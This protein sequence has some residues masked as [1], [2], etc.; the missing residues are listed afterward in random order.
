M[1]SVE[2][3]ERRQPDWSQ[4]GIAFVPM[5]DQHHQSRQSGDTSLPDFL[6]TH[7]PSSEVRTLADSP[8]AVQQWLEQAERKFLLL[9]SSSHKTTGHVQEALEAARGWG[10]TK[11]AILSFD[12]HSDMENIET[13]ETGHRISKS[14]VMQFVLEH[15]LADAVAVVGTE[16]IFAEKTPK[17]QRRYNYDIIP[18][19]ELYTQEHPDSAKLREVLDGIFPAWQAK[20]IREVYL[21]VDLD[22][23]RLPE[24][25]YTGVDYAQRGDQPYYGIPAAWIP[26]AMHQARTRY[27]LRLGVH[28]H[29]TGQ[30]MI[31]D[32]V[33][34]NVPDHKQRT[35]RIAQHILSAMLA[36]SQ[37]DPILPRS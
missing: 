4:A 5:T 20:G 27:G 13:G 6:A 26:L 12:H 3:R 23:L 11:R 10:T 33:E 35:A 7:L 19:H 24:Q 34:Y 1:A 17:A 28:N 2:R 8:T 25:S 30:R 31:G 16:R 9:T 18:G 29:R 22:S 32:V 37:C 15:N 14:N 21:S 36:E